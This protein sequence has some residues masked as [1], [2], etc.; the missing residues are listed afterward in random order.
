MKKKNSNWNKSRKKRN[1]PSSSLVNI[2][3]PL[4]GLKDE[5][6]I[7]QLIRQI[8]TYADFVGWIDDNQKE[9]ENICLLFMKQLEGKADQ[10][11]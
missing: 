7:E 10:V 3:P 9:N 4:R 1:F 6:Q 11:D 2:I 8:E 5:V